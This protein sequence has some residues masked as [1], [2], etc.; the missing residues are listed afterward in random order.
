[1]KRTNLFFIRGVWIF[2]FLTIGALTGIYAAQIQFSALI[3]ASNIAIITLALGLLLL[4]MQANRAFEKDEEEISRLKQFEEARLRKDEQTINH[5]SQQVEV[6]QVDEALKRIIPGLGTDFH[7]M[8]AYTEM[9]LQN[10][11]KE[12]EIVQG[13][14]FVLNDAD[15]M[16][17]ISGQ[18]AYFS[19]E[20]PRSFGL[21][22]NLTGQVAKNL[23]IL[24]IKDLPEGY[25]TILS[26]LGKSVP[27]Q[28]IIVPIIYNGTCIG[29][30]EL[31]SFKP[32]GENEEFL[33]RKI[34]ESMAKFL[35]ELR[36]H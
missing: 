16:Y 4:L 35:N 23:K 24:N 5:Q 15:Q 8:T 31:A 13:L 27:R 33:A 6:L 36:K 20:Q 34:G 9:V 10:I 1:M 29:I 26:G 19:E 22:E 30:M 3:F 25:I 17:H 2:V 12:L 18:Y 32:F 7:H 14:I 11:A 21:G 28:L